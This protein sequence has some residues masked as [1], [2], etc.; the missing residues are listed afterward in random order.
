MNL[1]RCS[2]ICQ[3]VNCSFFVKTKPGDG[4]FVTLVNIVSTISL[5]SVPY[6]FQCPYNPLDLQQKCEDVAVF[7]HASARQ[8]D[9]EW[10]AYL[11]CCK[12]LL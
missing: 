9:V 11:Q 8:D 12:T 6:I 5:E 4:D 10:P 1:I 7:L 3:A 2:E